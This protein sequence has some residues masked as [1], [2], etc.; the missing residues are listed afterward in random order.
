MDY[1]L[2]TILIFILWLAAKKTKKLLR[3]VQPEEKLVRR[4]MIIVRKSLTGME[5][6]HL[7]EPEAA[8]EGEPESEPEP[9][10]SENWKEISWEPTAAAEAG[11]K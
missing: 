2:V 8:A 4:E 7:V 11:V 6:T 5:N 3:R 10:T 1:A 9:A